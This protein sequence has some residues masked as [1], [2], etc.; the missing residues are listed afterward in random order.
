MSVSDSPR[1][2]APAWR[3]LSSALARPRLFACLDR[4]STL[5]VIDAPGFGKRT[6]IAGWLHRGG[7]P[8]HTIVWV[9]ELTASG[10]GDLP[11]HVLAVLAD[12]PAVEVAGGGP[13]DSPF[14]RVVRTFRDLGSP[15]LL[16][17]ACVSPQNSAEVLEATLRLLD[18]CPLLDA[19]VC[20]P[21]NSTDMTEVVLRGIDSTYVP[22]TDLAFT[23]E[24]TATLLCDA[25]PSAPTASARSCVACSVV[26]PPWSRR[27]R[28][29]PGAG[30][31]A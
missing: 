9:P 3:S 8:D 2:G 17:L 4:C 21:G 22:A 14:E 24:E 12:H 30:P 13:D 11:E 23:I 28:P 27:P 5:T 20:L 29:S 26:C 19:I 7:A 6:L 1:V 31:S 18:R 25:G 10:D 16:V 15:C